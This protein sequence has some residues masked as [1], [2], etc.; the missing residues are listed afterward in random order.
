M[1]HQQRTHPS[2]PPFFAAR[3]LCR[4]YAAKC[5]PPVNCSTHTER[6][7]T[8]ATCFTP[9]STTQFLPRATRDTF[10]RSASS[11]SLGSVGAQRKVQAEERPK[12][13]IRS[14]RIRSLGADRR[15]SMLLPCAGGWASVLQ[16]TGQWGRS[17]SRWGAPAMS[18]RAVWRWLKVFTPGMH[19]AYSTS[20]SDQVCLI[21]TSSTTRPTNWPRI[22]RDTIPT[23]TAGLPAAGAPG[24]GQ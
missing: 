24:G 22:S 13:D 11:P 10:I 12:G 15:R 23:S 7:V 17:S 9:Q 20:F 1:R 21:V 4:S 14:V 2:L 18:S 16:K 19:S 5:R 6:M 8:D 3:S